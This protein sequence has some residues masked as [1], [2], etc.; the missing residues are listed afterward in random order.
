MDALAELAK[1]LPDVN[2]TGLVF[3]KLSI[4]QEGFLLT[5][6]VARGKSISTENV[7]LI[8]RAL[9]DSELLRAKAEEVQVRSSNVAL[10][11]RGTYR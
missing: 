6:Q 2:K 3:T 5:G 8:E 4:T 9:N 7:S 1:R 11:L 10:R